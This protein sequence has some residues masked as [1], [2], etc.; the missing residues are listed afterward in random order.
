MVMPATAA[1]EISSCAQP[2]PT[3]LKASETGR[4]D[5]DFVVGHHA[6]Q[7]GSDG[8]IEQRAQYERDDDARW[9]RRAADSWPPP[10]AS[11]SNRNRCRRRKLWLAPAIIPTGAP[12][13]SVDPRTDL[14]KNPTP[15]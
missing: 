6:G 9:V 1:T 5:I 11:R 7:H 14:P 10:S 15:V 2:S 8:D 12:A 13:A 3:C 4:V